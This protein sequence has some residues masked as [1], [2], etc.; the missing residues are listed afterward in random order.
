MTLH[1]PANVD[2]VDN[3]RSLLDTVLT[4]T[5]QIPVLFPVHPRTR[6]RIAE[7][8]LDE[9]IK[10]SKDLILVDPQ[11]YL[12]F[13]CLL[14]G[15]RLVLSD[16]GSIQAETTVL[17]VPNLCLRDTTEWPETLS[18]GTNVLVGSS[19]EKILSEAFRILQL[20]PPKPVR[21][22]LWDGLA[23]RRIVEIL[24]DYSTRARTTL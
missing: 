6:L 16:S 9:V 12:D 10:R 2:N 5:S 23:A 20:D 8:G 7:T 17:G 21:P 24:I 13:L 3:L 4:V 22:P 19:P 18:Q 15:A 11:G 1:R 14:S